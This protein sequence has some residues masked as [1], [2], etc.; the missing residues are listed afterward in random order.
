MIA[1]AAIAIASSTKARKVH[2]VIAIWCVASETARSG[3]EA[4]TVTAT[5]VTRRD[6]RNVTVRI[7]SATPARAA[8][9]IP[10]RSGARDAPDARAPRTTTTSRAAALSSC[11]STVPIAE[12]AM[13]SPSNPP[14][15]YTSNRF[16][17][18][19]TPFP[20][21]ATTSGVR[22]SCSPRRTPVV[23]SITSSGV[24]PSHAMRRYV[25]ANPSTD[26]PAPNAPTSGS[27][28]ATPR[29]VTTT[30]ISTASQTPSIPCARAP[31]SSPAPTCRATLA[32]VPYARKMHSPTAVCSTTAAMPCP[33]S[34]GVPRW[35]DDR[36]VR[37]QE[38]RLGH[39]RQER[40]HREPQDLPVVGAS[41]LTILEPSGLTMCG[42]TARAKTPWTPSPIDGISPMI[43]SLDTW[44]GNSRKRR[45]AVGCTGLGLFLISSFTLGYFLAGG[46]G[47]SGGHRIIVAEL[48]GNGG[49]VWA[50][51][52]FLWA[53]VWD[54]P[55]IVI[56]VASLVLAAR[57]LMP[58]F[59][60]R[61][62]RTKGPNLVTAVI[63]AA[64]FFDLVEDAFLAVGVGFGPTSSP[65]WP[66]LWAAVFAISKFALLV[67]ALLILSTALVAGLSIPSWLF[68]KLYEDAAT[69]KV[70]NKRVA[71]MN[72]LAGFVN[73][74][75]LCFSGGGVRAASLTLGSL[76]EL[77]RG[78]RGRIDPTLGWS[79]NKRIT[80][81]SG[82]AYMAG[83]WQL[84][85]AYRTDAWQA[86]DTDGKAS[87]EEE[88]LLRNLGYLA[89]T[90]SRGHRGDL[91]APKLPGQADEHAERLR[92]GASVWA[93]IFT[94][95]VF[96][97]MV[98]AS[99]L[100]LTVI[101][102]TVVMDEL[103]DI[104]GPCE[105][106]QEIGVPRSCVVAQSRFWLPPVFWLAMG[107]LTSALWVWVSKM[108]TLRKDHVWVL[109][110]FKGATR[111]ML[112]LGL[113]LSVL[114]LGF[115]YLVQVV[116]RWDWQGALGALV[117]LAGALGALV[118]V[119]VKRSA[120]LAAK[121]GGVAF[122]ALLVLASGWLAVRILELRDRPDSKVFWAMIIVPAAVLFAAW[123][124]RPELWSL[125][126][127]Y[128][129][130][131]RI[132]YAVR[133]LVN[134]R[135][136]VA[137][138]NDADATA[139]AGPPPDQIDQEGGPDSDNETVA[140]PN[141]SD[142]S[143]HT[144]LTIC[145]AAHVTTRGVAAHYGIPA[146]S[147]TFTPEMVRTYVPQD[148][149][150]RF[151]VIECATEDLQACYSGAGRAEQRP[152]HDDVRGGAGRRR[153]R[154][155]D[156]A[157]PDRT[158]QRPHHLRQCA[159]RSLAPEPA[160]T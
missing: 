82:G 104:T 89:S 36:R 120:P 70:D 57:A 128:R 48:A 158:D 132:A 7:T 47:G 3:P 103:V 26:D 13:P 152:D 53:L 16:S 84:G 9:R 54:V 71:T 130:K 100:L 81:V 101:A 109:K 115:P 29:T 25:V 129:G 52:S 19:L 93:T 148:D 116:Y 27:V 23:A 24:V 86:E 78:P 139:V 87:S 92:S 31:C 59:R 144:P 39:Q 97:L 14:T 5:V 111:G 35:P 88:H 69:G 30:P 122:I 146:M 21:T 150:G 131:L 114:L 160:P 102:A 110:A 51:E 63:V 80:A 45:L 123:L 42:G 60:V 142:L 83:A 67:A 121:L 153:G 137:Y 156:G 64:G 126:A 65:A 62:L 20:S 55:Y 159:A 94:G 133:R 98:I 46:G 38:Q 73:E 124:V 99:A 28:K 117:G 12:P 119:L 106:R 90:W 49:G 66:F 75:G 105:L 41:H 138:V 136:A 34:S 68:K 79:G 145:A 4:P 149:E 91:G 1:C 43:S 112:A 147:F 37:E 32:V 56:Y 127:F 74:V 2:S 10:G 125:N 76:Q 143:G 118:R 151:E 72:E 95:F 154:S 157:V 50:R 85:R 40:R 44:L 141:L 135:T 108:R 96:N 77:E 18:M 134:G 113:A 15:P 11:A 107:A 58:F 61:L 22:V 140:E 8:E 155:G 6:A 17:T 33:A